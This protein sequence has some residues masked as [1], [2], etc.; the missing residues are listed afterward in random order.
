LVFFG[1]KKGRVYETLNHD[2]SIMT[3]NKSQILL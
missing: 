1:R 3:R 2:K